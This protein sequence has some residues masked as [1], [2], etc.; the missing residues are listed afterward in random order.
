M[1]I[2]AKSPLSDSDDLSLAATDSILA[3]FASADVQ[4]HA[5]AVRAKLL[6]LLE[7]AALRS[8]IS[9]AIESIGTHSTAGLTPAAVVGVLRQRAVELDDALD[10]ARTDR[11]AHEAVRKARSRV[12]EPLRTAVSDHVGTL[13]RDSESCLTRIDAARRASTMGGTASG[14]RYDNLVAA[15]LSREQIAALGP[16]VQSPD[17][18]EDALKARIS[19]NNDKVAALNAFI[20]TGDVAHLAGMGFDAL[21]AARIEAE[22]VSA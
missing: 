16:V 18:Q 20:A 8:E 17:A 19:A 11:D 5:A 9:A 7:F 6:S 15:G 1:R 22:Q 2:L 10:D 4:R 3:V 13:N 14:L 21:I 12:L